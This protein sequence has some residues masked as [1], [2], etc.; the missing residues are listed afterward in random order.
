MQQRYYT[1]ASKKLAIAQCVRKDILRHPGK[2]YRLDQVSKK[3]RIDKTSLMFAFK[4]AY[5]VSIIQFLKAQRVVQAKHLL[6]NSGLAVKVIARDCG[7]KDVKH[8]GT[9]FREAVGVTPT[10]Y[11]KNKWNDED[12]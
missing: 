5:G 3:Y 2:P 11:R 1:A 10:A 8:F 7:Y 4:Q 12:K 6:L 9:M